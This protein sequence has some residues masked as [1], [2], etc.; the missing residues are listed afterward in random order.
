MTSL[1]A[2]SIYNQHWL[3]DS[4]KAHR[5]MYERKKCADNLQTC[6]RRHFY[7]YQMTNISQIRYWIISPFLEMSYENDRSFMRHFYIHSYKL[8][9]HQAYKMY[10]ELLSKK[11]DD[12]NR[13]G[14]LRYETFKRIYPYI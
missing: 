14:K 5:K 2:F 13:I 3:I 1:K 11:H 9:S 4:N 6:L 10:E 7:Y 12:K 8:N